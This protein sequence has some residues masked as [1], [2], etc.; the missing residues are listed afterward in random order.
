MRLSMRTEATCVGSLHAAQSVA[1]TFV[2]AFRTWLPGKGGQLIVRN[3]KCALVHLAN[4]DNSYLCDANSGLA[5][6]HAGGVVGFELHLGTN[7]AG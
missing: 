5:R 1:Q 6:D 2:A 7:I 3:L 4:F